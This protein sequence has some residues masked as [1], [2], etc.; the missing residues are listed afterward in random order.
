MLIHAATFAASL[1]MQACAMLDV[2][3]TTLRTLW[4][5]PCSSR[6]ASVRAAGSTEEQRV[7]C[8]SKR[9]QLLHKVEIDVEQE[10]LGKDARCRVDLELPRH[11][12]GGDHTDEPRMSMFR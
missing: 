11:L 1:R 3:P 6:G 8:K 2:A 4:G 5:Q 12:R 7:A 10:R 9:L